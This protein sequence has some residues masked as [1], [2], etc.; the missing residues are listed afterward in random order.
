MR[1]ILFLTAGLIVLLNSIFLGGS[2]YG[3][4]ETEFFLKAKEFAFARKWEQAR[5]RLEEY[6]NR[7]PSGQFEAEAYYWLARSLNQL[8]DEVKQADDMVRLKERAIEN[9]NDLF[10]RH[11]D[12]IWQDDAKVL[13]I[14]IASALALL[15]RT[16]YKKYIEEIVAQQDG[17]DPDLLMAALEALTEL[18]PEAVLP[19]IEDVLNTQEDAAIRKQAVFLLGAYHGQAGL[20]IL[21]RVETSDPDESVRKEAAF[22]QKHI[23]M[24]SIPVQ[25]NYYGYTALLKKD[26]HLIQEGTLHV[27]DF[28]ALRSPGSKKVEKEIKKLF[29]GKLSDVKFTMGLIGGIETQQILRS[30]GLSMHVTHNLR[31]FKVEIPEDAIKKDYFRVQGTVSFFNTYRNKEHLKDFAV[32]E[33]HGQLM[34]MRHGDDV[35]I[36]VLQF[37]SLEEPLDVSEEPVYHTKFT[38]VFG[39]LVHSSRQS[40]NTEEMLGAVRGSVVD[41]GRAKAE[42]PSKEGKWILI[43]DIQLHSKEHLFIGRDAVL[44]DPKRN[45]VAEASEIIVPSDAPEKYE[46]K[47]K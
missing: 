25:L 47:N 44:Y 1:K 40:W 22:W 10:E 13:R 41:Y 46:I 20:S 24:E 26:R 42:I 36:L 43:G 33:D 15:G 12:S 3:D 4:E 29:N 34:A 5:T 31:G 2:F 11:P 9:L 37:E 38:N 17:G 7:Y 32:N 14:E 19:L 28:P 27:Y 6:L 21:H 35:A 16:Q 45:V 30:Q 23:H 8:S 18:Q 39:A